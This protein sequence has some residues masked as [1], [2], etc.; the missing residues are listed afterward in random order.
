MRSHVLSDGGNLRNACIPSCTAISNKATTKMSVGVTVSPGQSLELFQ[1][2]CGWLTPQ[3]NDDHFVAVILPA[4]KQ[5]L[6]RWFTSALC[7]VNWE[8][9][10]WMKDPGWL[11]SRVWQLVLPVI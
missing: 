4:L 7:G 11:H 5:G 3:M 1:F 9:P 2:S 6:T 8:A 10:L